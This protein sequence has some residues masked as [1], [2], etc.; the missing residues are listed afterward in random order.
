MGSAGALSLPD[1]CECVGEAFS[2]G[3][4]VGLRAR[5]WSEVEREFLGLKLQQDLCARALGALLKPDHVCDSNVDP[6]NAAA[7][8]RPPCDLRVRERER[9]CDGAVALYASRM[10]LK[11][12]RAEV[13]LL[14]A[15]V[16]SNSVLRAAQLG[17]FIQVDIAL[18]PA[19]HGAHC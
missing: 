9:P 19:R 13:N 6:A 3:A 15:C 11:E 4:P 17:L 14:L 16:V 1:A 18:K 7:L 12:Y 5:G 8:R 10:R 2:Y